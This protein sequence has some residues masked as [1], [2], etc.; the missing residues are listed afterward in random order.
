MRLLHECSRESEAL[1][2]PE[3][4]LIER[5]GIPRIKAHVHET[6]GN[7]LP[8][9]NVFDRG[10]KFAVFQS[11]EVRQ[12]RRVLDEKADAWRKRS[13]F[14]GVYPVDD[15]APGRRIDQPGYGTKKHGFSRAVGALDTDDLARFDRK[16]DVAQDL[17]T[18]NELANIEQLNHGSHSFP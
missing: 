16:G 9:Y 12:K 11:S 6:L 14:P 2:H 10:E 4:V 7:L 18:L 15:N 1:L 3:R 8:R 5:T 17:A 13:G